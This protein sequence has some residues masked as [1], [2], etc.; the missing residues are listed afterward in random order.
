MKLR[1]AIG[2]NSVL[3]LVVASFFL[4]QCGS[5]HPEAQGTGPQGPAGPQGQ[6][7]PAGPTGP[8]GPQGPASA[9]LPVFGWGAANNGGR[10]TTLGTNYNTVLAGVQSGGHMFV[11][12]TI[13]SLS[14]ND[15]LSCRISLDQVSDATL[16]DGPGDNFGSWDSSG[17]NS[18][19]ET[20]VH[21]EG[22]LFS[23]PSQLVYLQC[24]GTRPDSSF[25]RA[26]WH[27]I[28]VQ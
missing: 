13:Y 6:V 2:R 3:F 5:F 18:L 23:D 27:F 22:N 28:Q 24:K 16:E 4:V 14:P 8:Q 12:A 9:S 15:T 26:S 19:G 25:S 11:T 21:G 1:N 20:V 17:L 10:N 7:G